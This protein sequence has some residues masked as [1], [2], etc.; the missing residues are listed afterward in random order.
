MTGSGVPEGDALDVSIVQRGGVASVTENGRTERMPLSG[1]DDE[2]G[3]PTAM[4][5]LA[6]YVKSVSV[7]ET[8]LRGRT[9]DRIGGTL[10]TKALLDDTGGLTAT[11]LGLADVHVSDIRAVLFVPR[12]THLVE[13]MFADFDIS[14]HNEKAHVHL[15]FAASDIDKPVSI[16]PA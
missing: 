15:S 9:A 13:V 3:S 8:D 2:F 10:D 6:R 4:L 1:A 5:D 11:L 14:A 16:P 7:G 12:D